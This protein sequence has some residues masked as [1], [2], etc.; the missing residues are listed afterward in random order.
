MVVATAVVPWATA[1]EVDD[2]HPLLRQARENVEQISAQL[3]R[4]KSNE[5]QAASALDVVDERL[6]E[7]E[8]RVNEA[9]NAVR[10]QEIAV[11]LAGERLEALRLEAEALE[12]DLVELAVALFVNGGGSELE[13]VLASGDVQAAID[14]TAFL[15]VVTE[16]DRIALEQARAARVALE[17]QRQRF[18]LEMERLRRMAAEEEALLASVQEL[19]AVRAEALVAANREVDDLEAVED[20]LSGD[21]ERIEQLIANAATTPV[22]ASPPSSQGF[23]WPVCSRVTSS[24]GYRW[25]R[26]HRGID[27]AGN[28]GDPIAAAK[29]GTVIAA[30]REGGYGKLVLIDHQDGIVTAYAHQSEVVV[31]PGQSVERG[32]R[33]GSVGNTGNSTGSH[34]HL[35]TRVNGTAVNPRQYLPNGC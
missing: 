23:I 2:D 12:A 3:E 14:R 30:G 13:L 8:Q 27:L 34:L 16:T 6:A 32:E 11:E 35:E 10:N 19:R 31:V 33:I 20:D 24:F 28:A 22:A 26:Q 9:S 18:D 15:S 1:A 7:V 17:A 29:A 5:A 21:Y 4:A 25:G